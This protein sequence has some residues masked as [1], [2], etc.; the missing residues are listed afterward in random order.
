M[1]EEKDLVLLDDYLANR[2]EGSERVAF[3]LKLQED[4]ELEAALQSQKRII[5]GL[6]RA[7][8]AELKAM[9]QTIPVPPVAPG[10]SVLMKATIGTFSAALVGT[11]L[12]FSFLKADPAPTPR[13]QLGIAEQPSI[14]EPVTP[15]PEIQNEPTALEEEKKATSPQKSIRKK[16][17]AASQTTKPVIDAFNPTEEPSEPVAGTEMEGPAADLT[18]HVSTKPSITAEINTSNKK[19]NFHYML[20]DDRLTLYGGFEKNIYE[21]IEVFNNDKR[22]AFLYYK[23]NYY[24]LNASDTRVKPLVAIQDPVLLEKLKEYRNQQ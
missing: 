4:A 22:T 21:I 15:Q 13:E 11:V 9:L 8:M 18:T 14:V 3:E 1:A 19:Y 17:T 16:D 23:S 5:D 7:R 6:R 20:I 12:Y 10:M 24:L 2:L